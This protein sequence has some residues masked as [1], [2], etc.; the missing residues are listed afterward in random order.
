[1]AWGKSF[2]TPRPCQLEAPNLPGEKAVR[3]W[4]GNY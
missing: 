3:V 1:M 2:R 4:Y